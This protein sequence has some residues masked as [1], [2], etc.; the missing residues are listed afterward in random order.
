MSITVLYVSTSVSL[1][2]LVTALAQPGSAIVAVYASTAFVH[3]RSSLEQF[4]GR[5]AMDDQPSPAGNLIV[6]TKT[7][8]KRSIPAHR[9]P[10]CSCFERNASLLE[11]VNRSHCI[12]WPAIAHVSF[13]PTLCAAETVE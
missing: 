12:D 13:T 11:N 1:I 7:I 9:A 8:S 6:P 4:D 5:H 2:E 3:A 10:G